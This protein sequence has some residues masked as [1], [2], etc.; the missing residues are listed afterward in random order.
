MQRVGIARGVSILLLLL[1]FAALGAQR[2]HAHYLD[3]AQFSVY[4]GDDPLQLRLQVSL[5]LHLDP[6]LPI[7]LADDCVLQQRAQ[8]RRSTTWRVDLDVLCRTQAAGVLQTQWGRDG[9]TLR[10]HAQD[11]SAVSR[12]IGGGAPGVTLSLPDPFVGQEPAE[13][14]RVQTAGHYLSM[15]AVH[16]LI[17]W[18]HLA[19]VLCLTLLASGLRLIALVTAFTL[20]HSLSLGLAHFGVIKLSTAPVEA[21]IAMS[22]V[23]M[24][25]EAWLQQVPGSTGVATSGLRRM[26][27][28]VF[29]G[30]IHGL[31]FAS[32]LGDLGV[33]PSQRFLALV[34]F[35]VGVE[36][37]QI[38]FVLAVVAAVYALR[39]LPAERWLLP[40]L[41][42]GV[43]GLGVFWTFERLLLAG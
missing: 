11:G 41:T 14:G 39:R 29:F 25:R 37:G 2:A 4:P 1:L 31:G 8:T 10:H 30:L 32:V 28:T 9:A 33:E 23:F 42:A 12:I 7:T 18:D 36:L 20:G 3:I 38:A 6:G 16:V 22:I 35:N 15:G 43:G 40:G 27:I 21:I 34:F 24:A 17:G 26:L 5:P 19:F 13:Q